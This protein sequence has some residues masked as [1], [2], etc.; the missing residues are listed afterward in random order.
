MLGCAVP[1][2]SRASPMMGILVPPA[3]AIYL[4]FLRYF[5]HQLSLVSVIIVI[6]V[7]T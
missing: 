6:E 3:L 7:Y 1:R 2:E 4:Y 5:F